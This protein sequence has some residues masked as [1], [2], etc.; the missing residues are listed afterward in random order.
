M[1]ICMAVYCK[2]PNLLCMCGLCPLTQDTEVILQKFLSGPSIR[3]FWDG[4]HQRGCCIFLPCPSL[5]LVWYSAIF[6]ATASIVPA[7]LTRKVAGVAV[8]VGANGSYH[9]GLPTFF[10]IVYVWDDIL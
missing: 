10:S 1:G 8:E 3:G 9:H 2:N 5:N 7:L 4:S 6:P